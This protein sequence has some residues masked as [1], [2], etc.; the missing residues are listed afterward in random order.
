MTGRAL[1]TV[2]Y[3]LAALGGM[4]IFNDAVDKVIAMY[5]NPSVKGKPECDSPSD[6]TESL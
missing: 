2:F 3:G 1:L 5:N 6:S 4:L